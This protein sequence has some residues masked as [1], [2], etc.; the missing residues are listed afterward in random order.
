MKNY[1]LR[2][3]LPEPISGHWDGGKKRVFNFDIENNPTEDKKGYF[4]KVGSWEANFWANVA[5]YK[6]I[7]RTLS[8]IK[9]HFGNIGKWEYIE[10]SDTYWS[11]KLEKIFT[12]QLINK[13]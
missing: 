10:N 12:N 9:R 8:H 13:K 4:V 2:L 7:K 3:T 5:V 6:S 11:D 1:T